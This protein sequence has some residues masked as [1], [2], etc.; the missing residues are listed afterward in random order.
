MLMEGKG[1][2]TNT[3]KEGFRF[4][5]P[6]DI[7]CRSWQPQQASLTCEVLSEW[8]TVLNLVE[9]HVYKG[10]K[11]IYYLYS[12]YRCLTTLLCSVCSLFSLFLFSVCCGSCEFWQ[13]TVRP[14]RAGMLLRFLSWNCSFFEPFVCDAHL[15]LGTSDLLYSPSS[16]CWIAARRLD[17]G[18]LMRVTDTKSGS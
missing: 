1:P 8:W 3:R 11:L 14:Q 6:L 2:W 16:S 4:T 17:S 7:K 15:L 18:S 12:C 10:L 13:V 5:V 9:Q